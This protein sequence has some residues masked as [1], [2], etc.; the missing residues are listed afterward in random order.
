MK[1]ELPLE[2]FV[3]ISGLAVLAFID[4]SIHHFT[5]CP[6]NNLG[7]DWCPG[8]GIGRSLSCLLHF[9]LYSSF[10]HHWFGIPALFILLFR[11]WQLFQKFSLNYNLKS[12]K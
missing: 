11:I 10:K 1:S 12:L 5:L 9:E 7:L 6:F 8:C 3:W 4:P 2:M